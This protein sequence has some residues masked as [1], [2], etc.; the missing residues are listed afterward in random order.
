MKKQKD[1]KPLA[2]AAAA[3]I[4]F[5]GLG[6]Y[7]LYGYH[8]TEWSRQRTE[9]KLAESYLQELAEWSRSRASAD[10]LHQGETQEAAPDETES[11]PGYWQSS[12]YD[13]F[14]MGDDYDFSA[15]SWE[16]SLD[17]LWYL[18]EGLDFTPD[19]GE[20]VVLGVLEVPSAGICRPVYAGDWD[21]LE[22]DLGRWMVT[23]ARPDYIPSRTHLCIQCRSLGK[24]TGLGFSGLPD[25]ALGEGFSLTCE[26]GRYEYR[27]TNIFA[28]S[29]ETAASWY[30]DD[31]YLP[32]TMCYLITG[33]RN[34][35]NILVEGTLERVTPIQ[36]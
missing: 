18:D 34:G 11:V 33:G 9:T 8:W 28:V 1:K 32:M 7:Y 4:L 23:A 17:S 29:E 20:G 12:P 25:L 30:V 31:F 5:L 16:E 21:V 26:S 6:I 22:W 10:D 35:E 2:I 27:I 19:Y 13:E 36:E 14:W 24:T 3:A 15:A